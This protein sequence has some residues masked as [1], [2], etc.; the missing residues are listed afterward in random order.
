[1]SERIYLIISGL[2]LLIFLYLDM[3]N[4]VFGYI[5]LLI[6]EGITN[7]RVPIII[8]KL[9]YGK[10]HKAES[11]INE[12]YK[13]NFEAERALRLVVAGILIITYA[14]MPNA[15]WFLP[16]FVGVMLT[17]AGFSKFC[18]MVMALRWIGLK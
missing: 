14:Y 3:D 18:P 13:I 11:Y 1:M 7:L 15:A 17:F 6:F 12:K 8:S 16:W 10:N 4:L 9:R 5:A 2:V